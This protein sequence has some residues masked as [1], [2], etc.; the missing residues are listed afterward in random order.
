[1]AKIDSASELQEAILVL[2]AKQKEEMKRLKKEFDDVRERMKPS[3]LLHE[4]LNKIKHSASL[5]KTLIIAGVGIASAF[6]IKKFSKRRRRHHAMK[7]KYN[8]QNPAT[9]QVKRVSGSLIQYILA[10]IISRNAEKIKSVI[11]RLL[12]NLKTTKTTTDTQVSS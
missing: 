4:G 3:N 6:A 5:R 10:A 11:Y 9:N 8:Y 2:E 1:M 12:S 7:M